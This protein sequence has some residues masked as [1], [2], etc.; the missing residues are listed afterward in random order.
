MF[1]TTRSKA[2]KSIVI[3][4]LLSSLTLTSLR[5]DTP[6]VRR[7]SSPRNSP[8][9]S[10]V[11]DFLEDGSTS[12]MW[13]GEDAPDHL[14]IHPSPSRRV[15]DQ[16]QLIA[17][18]HNL[19]RYI[20]GFWTETSQ[21]IFLQVLRDVVTDGN[22]E[23]L[24]RC[25]EN[26][27]FELD[28]TMCHVFMNASL[29]QFLQR[30]A[31]EAPP[32]Q[33]ALSSLLARLSKAYR[34]LFYKSVVA[35]TASDQEDKVAKHLKLIISLQKYISG[36]QFWMHDAEMISVL[37]LSDVGKPNQESLLRTNP[38]EPAWGSTTL[39]QCVVAAEFMWTVRDLRAKQSDPH[40][41][42]EADEVAKKFLIDLERRLAV[43]MAAKEKTA[44]I[45]LPLRVL[46]C[47]IFLETR[48]FCNTTHRPGW[49]SRAMEWA[50]QPVATA[51]F[52][53][54]TRDAI[55]SS[56]V[57]HHRYLDDVSLTFQRM[58]IVY[59][60]VV[61][62]FETVHGQEPP[63]P[64]KSIPEE[65]LK[66]SL[67]EDEEEEDE[68]YTSHLPVQTRRQASIMSMYPISPA[69]AASLDIS[70]GST[71]HSASIAMAKYRLENLASVNNDPFGAVFS[72]LVAV[73]TAMSS[74]DFSRMVQ[75]LWESFIVDSNA[76]AFVPAA[77]LLMQCGERVPQQVVQIFSREFYR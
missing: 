67:Y 59:A 48:F 16:Q 60:S 29:P 65:L 40:R 30:L 5:K 36:V 35:C 69:A 54:E 42:M 55:R 20:E 22:W 47:N 44:L 2:V 8:Q 72:L 63:R 23:R 64:E 68:R 4:M 52:F 39:G 76:R 37:L 17:W 18:C 28:E 75:P 32:C 34:P 27:A 38:E 71:Q 73:F 10:S 1:N 43:F 45:P 66:V 7:P 61:D 46:L 24:T 6:P 62:Q 51:E 41:D 33:P 21:P 13:T 53:Q 26:L 49:L 57:L 31:D 74:Q 50:T 14:G 15:S 70:P 19:R 25:Y 12:S 9:P 3:I 58:Q 77:F 56:A 11:S